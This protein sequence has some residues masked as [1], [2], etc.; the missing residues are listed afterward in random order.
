GLRY[1]SVFVHFPNVVVVRENTFV[2]ADDDARAE[3]FERLL[4][5]SLRKLTTEKFTQRFIG[6]RKRQNALRQALSGEHCNNG[7]RDFLDDGRE[8]RDRPLRRLHRFLRRA[9]KRACTDKKHRQHDARPKNSSHQGSLSSFK[10]SRARAQLVP[11][12][13]EREARIA[14]NR[15]RLIIRNKW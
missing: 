8:A 7:R 3:A 5:L 2:G 14:H 10:E 12:K 4:A 1:Q 9:R 15:I 6:K 11:F 13:R